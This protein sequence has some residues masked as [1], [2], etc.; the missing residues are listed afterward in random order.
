MLAIVEGSIEKVK[1]EM[2]QIAKWKADE[3]KSVKSQIKF[4][5]ETEKKAAKEEKRKEN[6]YPNELGEKLGALEIAK[7][8]YSSAV[9]PVRIGDIVINY[10]V[11]LKAFSKLKGCRVYPE[12]I[13]DKELVINYTDDTANGK[14][15]LYDISKI[16]SELNSMPIAEINHNA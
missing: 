7:E 15:H 9:V 11:Y 14:I 5:K 8:K 4:W 10:T 16:Y 12:E 6:A 1:A 3:I 2:K 13:H